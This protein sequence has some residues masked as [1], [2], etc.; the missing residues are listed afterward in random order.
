MD[1]FQVLE[2]RTSVRAFDPE[3]EVSAEV[4]D[5]LLA[6]AIRAP[7]AGNRQPWHFYVVRDPAVRRQLAA[8]QPMARTLWPR[9]PSPS[10]S[11]PFPGSRRHATASGGR[12]FT[13]FRTQQQRP[14][15]SSWPPSPWALAAAGW[16]PLT[17]NGLRGR[18][19]FPHNTVQSPSCPSAKQ[20]TRLAPVPRASQC[21]LWRLLLDSCTG[22]RNQV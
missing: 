8:A 9:R 10:S 11:V 5:R 13:A 19:I 2:K 20:S 12:N 4:L 6:A 3:V 17:S 15:I 14:S 22:A 7:S 18:S 1:F 21:R 16:A